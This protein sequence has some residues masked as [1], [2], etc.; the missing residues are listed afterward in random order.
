MSIEEKISI[1]EGKI[2]QILSEVSEL[3]HDCIEGLKPGDDLREI[4]LNSLTSVELI[5]KLEEAFNITIG[6]DDLLLD[7]VSSID[8]IMQLLDKYVNR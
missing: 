4:G 1:E 3:K 6:D 5:V 8:K 2:R 7:S